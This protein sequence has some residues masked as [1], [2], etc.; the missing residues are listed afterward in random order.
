MPSFGMICPLCRGP[1][2]LEL[3]VEVWGRRYLN[4]PGCGLV[5]MHP[6][7][8]PSA[9]E[10]RARYETHENDPEDPRY[11]A[12][13]G[14][15]TTPLLAELRPGMRGLD[16][17]CGPGP[18]LGRMLEEAGMQVALWD[19]FFVPDPEVL[20]GR[21]RYDFI[22]CTETAEHF[23]DPWEAFSQMDRLL[24][25]GGW[26]GIMTDPV[27]EAGPLERWYYLRDPT[28]VALFRPRTLAWL[29]EALGWALKAAPEPRVTLFQK[30]GSGGQPAR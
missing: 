2:G 14:R 20:Q 7:D 4:C 8:R 29:G 12:F 10:E 24:R 17:G 21:A 28:H 25:P 13:L 19:P 11:R 30:Q 18:A 1:E 27:P 15:L 23:F 6:E 26:V 5:S 22:T 3:A 16:Y 9:G